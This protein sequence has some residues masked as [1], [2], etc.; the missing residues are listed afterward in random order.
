[1]LGISG[2]LPQPGD[3]VVV[4][5][6]GKMPS[7][8]RPVGSFWRLVGVCFVHDIMRGEVVEQMQYDARYIAQDFDLFLC[9]T[10]CVDRTMLRQFSQ[11]TCTCDHPESLWACEIQ[12]AIHILL[13]LDDKSYMS[14]VSDSHAAEGGAVEDIIGGS[15]L[16][17]PMSIQPR[18]CCMVSN[19]STD[20][21]RY[22]RGFC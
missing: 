22:R 7:I 14:V 20:D 17:A 4:L 18:M 15:E 8:L 3:E 9:H 21:R 12:R 16:S 6:G 5:F 11:L 2:S 1:M 10:W 13:S 19:R